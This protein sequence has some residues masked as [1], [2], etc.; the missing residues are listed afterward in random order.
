MPL[1]HPLLPL[2]ALGL[3]IDQVACDEQGARLQA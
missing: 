3:G 2:P 1:I